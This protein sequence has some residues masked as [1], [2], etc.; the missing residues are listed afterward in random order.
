MLFELNEFQK[1]NKNILVEL[2]RK[3]RYCLDCSTP[4]SGKTTTCISVIKEFNKPTL[5]ICPK[6]VVSVWLNMKKISNDTNIIGVIN[7]DKIKMGNT[8]YFTSNIKHLKNKTDVEKRVFYPPK[9]NE[10]INEW[11]LNKD[12]LIVFDEIH[13][14]KN[15]KTQISNLL[16]S[17]DINK[18]YIYGISGTI[19]NAPINLVSLFKTVGLIK[20]PVEFLLKTG[21]KKAQLPAKGFV[22]DND[23]DLLIQLHHSMFINKETRIGVRTTDQEFEKIM[24]EQNIFVIELKLDDILN[25]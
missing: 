23:S 4:G 10:E 14:M 20:N 3:K 2:L 21:Y 17:L 24:P 8:Q 1:E 6:Q 22:F 9:V 15:Y 11:K 12:T 18:Y 16:S 7:Y 19:A 13:Y 25:N 5:I